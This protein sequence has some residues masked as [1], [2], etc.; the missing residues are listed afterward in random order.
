MNLLAL[1]RR[2]IRDLGK[3]YTLVHQAQQSPNLPASLLTNLLKTG[4]NPQ[5][6]ARILNIVIKPKVIKP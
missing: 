1:G 2:K 4:I 5:L 6:T 3:Q